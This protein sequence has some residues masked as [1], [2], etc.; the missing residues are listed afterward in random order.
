VV[1]R[2]EFFAPR[3]AARHVGV[4][5]A[6]LARWSDPNGEGCP[7]LGGKVIEAEEL[8]TAYGRRIRYY[9]RKDLDRARQAQRDLVRVPEFPGLTY[10]Y[11][12]TRKLGVSERTLRR[13]MEGQKPPVFI[14][15]KTAKSKDGRPLK[16]SYVP[17][18]FVSAILATRLQNPVPADM[19]T[20]EEAAA[21]LGC[22]TMTVYG[23]VRRGVLKAKI[24]H[25][26]VEAAPRDAKKSPP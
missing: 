6:T 16:R 11:H 9:A 19:A 4:T 14:V 18:E 10:L 13:L 26:L 24:G 12:A 21:E 23:L 1:S 8:P 7:L 15:E 22:A 20:V 2:R 5:Q 17:T 3:K 25:K